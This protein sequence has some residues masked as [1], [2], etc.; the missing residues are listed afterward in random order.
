MYDLVNMDTITFHSERLQ[1]MMSKRK[2]KPGQLEYMSGVSQPMISL[3]LDGS[4]PNVSAVIVGKLADALGCSVDYL[5][6]L[7]EDSSPRPMSVSDALYELVRTARQLPKFRLEDLAQIA[8]MY[9]AQNEKDDTR[10]MDIVLEKINE[11]GGDEA[12]QLLLDLLENLRSG[13]GDFGADGAPE[14]ENG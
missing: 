4:R 3:L 8:A 1:E 13:G 12:E 9:L 10:L 6:G 2:L 7:T 14:D 5:V 11:L